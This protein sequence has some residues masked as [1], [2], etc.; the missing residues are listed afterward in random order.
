[1]R[2]LLK[3]VANM[4]VVWI[5]KYLILCFMNTQTNEFCKQKGFIVIYILI[6]Q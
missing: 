6:S 3:N 2:F 1:M 4:L 5:F